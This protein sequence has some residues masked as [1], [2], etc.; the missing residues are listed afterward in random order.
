[1]DKVDEAA[2]KVESGR[3]RPERSYANGNP[4]FD[5]MVSAIIPRSWRE[6]IFY[7]AW[8]TSEFVKWGYFCLLYTSDAADE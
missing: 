4:R 3:K 7:G 6:G 5:R 2:G 1:M 8:S